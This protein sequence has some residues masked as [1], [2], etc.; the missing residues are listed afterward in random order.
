MHK[1]RLT[2]DELAGPLDVIL[3]LAKTPAPFKLPTVTKTSETAAADWAAADDQVKTEGEAKAARRAATNGTPTLNRATLDFI[4]EGAV[5][6]DRHRLL[7]SAAANLREFG[8]PPALAV[9]L[10]EES[11]LDSGLPPKDVRRGIECGLAAAGSAPPHQDASQSPQTDPDGSTVK[12][13]P[14]AAASDPGG[15]DGQTCQRSTRATTLTPTEGG[16]AGADLQAALA[17]LWT[18]TPAA[19]PADVAEGPPADTTPA[20]PKVA[21]KAK[22]PPVLPPDPPPLRPLPP[23][24]VGS[25]TLDKPCKCGSTEYV[26]IPIPEGR[27]RRDCRK[28]GRFAGWGRWH[29]Q[30]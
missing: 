8:C 1:R 25:G 23:G 13:P 3:E 27:T 12:E 20:P 15:S 24:A 26:E 16:I 6:G 2:L 22:G 10:L 18:S 9:A 17:K 7:F 28:C 5:A 30:G 29:D 19:L 14:E 21:D 11:A 4:R